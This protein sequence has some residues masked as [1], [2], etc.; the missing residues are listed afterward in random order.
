VRKLVLLGLVV[1]VPVIAQ[2]PL[3]RSPEDAAKAALM[4][5]V[6]HTRDIDK[7]TEPNASLLEKK[8]FSYQREPP[9]FLAD[10]KSSRFGIAQYA[11][12]ISTEGEIWSIGY[13]SA[14]C[15]VVAMM[16]DPAEVQKGYAGV[17]GDG[18]WRMQKARAADEGKN[19]EHW[20]WEP[21]RQYRVLADVNFRDDGI[22][23][24]MVGRES[25]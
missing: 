16:A 15:M 14:T 6:N 24:V 23:T 25:K 8:G 10:T 17:L 12:S 13:N 1:S 11:R 18:K 3:A 5:C 21:D 7:I 9:E 2:S 22:S 4:A 19:I 20:R